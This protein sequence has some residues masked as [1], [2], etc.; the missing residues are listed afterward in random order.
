MSLSFDKNNFA[1]IEAIPENLRS[2]ELYPKISGMMDYIVKQYAAEF[3]DVRYK[4]RGPDKVRD[5]VIKEIITELGFKYIADVMGTISNFEFNTFLQ[6]VSLI[7]LLKGSRVGLELVLKLLG[8]DTIIK[9]WWEQSPE[10][11]V[12]T[13][14]IVVIMDS[15]KV[16]DA[17]ATLDKVKIFARA[18]VFPLIEN[19]DFRFSL[20]IGARNLTPAGFFKLHYSTEIPILGRIP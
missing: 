17:Q 1:A 16:T 8:F 10:H 15:N 19:I 6:F 5:I 20:N 7:N 2:L 4:Y 18:Y 14:E 9:E 3:E 12:Y 11:P 13:F